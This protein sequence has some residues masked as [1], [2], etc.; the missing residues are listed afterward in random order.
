[1][2]LY[3]EIF[4]SPNTNEPKKTKNYLKKI[5]KKST[6][7]LLEL[8]N[9]YENINLNFHYKIFSN[10]FIITFIDILI[11]TNFFLFYILTCHI[12]IFSIHFF[13]I[14]KKYKIKNFIKKLIKN[15]KNL[16]KKSN[17]NSKIKLRDIFIVILSKYKQF[18]INKDELIKRMLIKENLLKKIIIKYKFLNT[19]Y[20]MEYFE[21]IYKSIF[22]NN[23]KQSILIYKLIIIFIIFGFIAIIILNV[24]MNIIFIFEYTLFNDSKNEYIRI[25]YII[26]R[27]ENESPKQI[28]KRFKNSKKYADYIFIYQNKKQNFILK[29]IFKMGLFLMLYLISKYVIYF[30]FRNIF[31]RKNIFYLLKNRWYFNL[32]IIDFFYIFN[33]ILKIRNYFMMIYQK[34][35]IKNVLK[36]GQ[37]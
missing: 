19:K 25:S 36:D 32:K 13:L 18:H 4:Q 7:E 15:E 2:S 21:F 1:M 20:H 17:L 23:F 9:E 8:F 31:N 14:Y 27:Q 34:Y 11:F 3:N 35:H 29:L 16:N 33:L 30:N 10:Y 24:I 6:Q 5:T 12:F 37:N 22:F 26:Y 28:F